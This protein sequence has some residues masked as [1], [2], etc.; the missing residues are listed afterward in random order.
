M[1]AIRWYRFFTIA[2]TAMVALGA[3]LAPVPALSLAGESDVKLSI[4]FDGDRVTVEAENASLDRILDIRPRP[5]RHNS[6]SGTICN[7]SAVTL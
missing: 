3:I 7:Q 1:R 6:D 5:L 4:S 2:G